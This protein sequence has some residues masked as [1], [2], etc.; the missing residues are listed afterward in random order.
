M[1]KRPSYTSVLIYYVFLV[2]GPYREGEMI[3]KGQFRHT[4][5]VMDTHIDIHEDTRAL[6]PYVQTMA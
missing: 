2:A 3:C 4:N 6:L 5:K 1:V